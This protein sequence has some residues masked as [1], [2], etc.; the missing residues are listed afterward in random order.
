MNRIS[1]LIKLLGS[2]A[3]RGTFA[4]EANTIYIY[5]VIVGSD[6]EAEWF[7][8]ISP[9]PFIDAL[10]GMTGDVHLRINSPGGDV[11]GANAMAQAMREYKNGQIVAHVDGIAASA[12]S[13]L[14]ITAD[15]TVMAP[16]SLMM[17]HNAWTMAA[18]DR[19][20]FLD[21][22]SILEKVDGMLSQG[23]AAKSGGN[24][25]AF[26]VMMDAETWFTPEE[27][28]AAGLANSVA[29]PTPSAKASAAWDLSA[30]TN[31]PKAV[32]GLP[33]VIR[34]TTVTETSE[35]CTE[36][37][38]ETVEVLSGDPSMA[39]EDNN[40]KEIENRQRRFAARLLETAA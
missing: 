8:G 27:A 36:V 39:P 40:Q 28:V 17:I 5:D 20:D 23:Y 3:K 4:A 11:F 19:H 2:N 30:F 33:T 35:V 6:V 38:T 15:Q 14:A 34:T 25:S 13:V 18:G 32:V 22:A 1:N 31:A 29:E 12:A 7:G 26:A 21:T 37:E 9:K 10:N 24:A 16:G